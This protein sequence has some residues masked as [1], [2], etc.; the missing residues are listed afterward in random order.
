M[1]DQK[2]W[3]P[4]PG[5]F[6]FFIDFSTACAQQYSSAQ[7]YSAQGYS[8]EQ[9]QNEGS[10]SSNRNKRDKLNDEMVETKVI[11][12]NQILTYIKCRSILILSFFHRPPS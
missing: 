6:F 10:S 11:N 7:P 9:P 3:V 2:I 12:V 4:N 5:F 1:P 8:S